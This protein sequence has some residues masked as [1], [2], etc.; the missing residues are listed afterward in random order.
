MARANV[1]SLRGTSTLPRG[2]GRHVVLPWM[3][4]VTLKHLSILGIAEKLGDIMSGLAL[5][6]VPSLLKYHSRAS[7]TL[8]E[9]VCLHNIAGIRNWRTHC[10][11]SRSRKCRNSLPIEGDRVDVLLQR[12][13][14]FQ[15]QTRRFTERLDNKSVSGGPL[16]WG[17]KKAH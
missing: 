3:I 15:C 11:H 10:W 2:S 16:P 7:E 9:G 1:P 6:A 8:E 12:T 5:I 14:S 13:Q 4:D 17:R